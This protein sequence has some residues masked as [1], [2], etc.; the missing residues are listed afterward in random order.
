MVL[1]NV[2][3]PLIIGTALI[4][5]VNPCAIGVMILLCTYLVKLSANRA[6][7]LLVGGIHV[8]AVYVTYFLAGIG[9]LYTIHKL[10]IAPYVGVFVALVVIVFG[11]VELKDY[12]WYGK[13]FSLRINPK[14]AKSIKKYAKKG[15]IPAVTGLGVM[16]AAVE[17]PCTGGPYLAI[18]ALLAQQFDVT[19]VLYLL[20]YNFIFVLPLLVI[21]GMAYFGVSH[22]GM[23]KWKMKYRKY[24][25]LATGL[26]MIM[27]GGLLLWYYLGFLV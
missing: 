13:G 26:V 1:E 16:V 24:M 6:R 5:S 23:K 8:A 7:M 10:N 18:T 27:L 17:L 22:V 21:L 11:F 14:Y 20:L 25:R 3:L 19:A 2:T 9:L 15:T 12:F 4:D